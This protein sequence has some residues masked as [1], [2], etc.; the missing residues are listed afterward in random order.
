MYPSGTWNGHWEQPGYGRQ[1]M[2]DFVLRFS[3][4]EI[5]GEGRDLVGPFTIYGACDEHGA[6]KFVKQ[7]TGKHAVRY[8]GL[9]DGEGTIFGKWII[10]P[11]WSGTF[12]LKPVH[13]KTDPN[14]PIHEI[15]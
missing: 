5:T 6:V 15:K 9:H 8:E 7:Y 4:R 1:P 3:G 14:L 2:H 11:A 10:P 13:S 12:A